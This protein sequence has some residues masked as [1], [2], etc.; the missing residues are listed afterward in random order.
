MAVVSLPRGLCPEGEK[1]D[2]VIRLS[3]IGLLFAINDDK[4]VTLAK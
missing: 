1:P 3:T 2:M 4:F